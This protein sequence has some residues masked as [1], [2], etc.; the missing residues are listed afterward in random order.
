MRSITL[1]CL[2]VALIFAFSSQ[3]L[4]PLMVVPQKG[5][6]HETY[7]PP[8]PQPQTLGLGWIWRAPYPRSG[9]TYRSQG[10]SDGTYFYIVGGWDGTSGSGGPLNNLYRY[11]P[12]TNT[13]T[14]RAA[15][16]VAISNSYLVYSEADTALYVIG[17]YNPNAGGILNTLQRYKIATNSWSLRASLPI[18][19][20]LGSAVAVGDTIYYATGGNVPAPGRMWKYSITANAWDTTGAQC[21]TQQLACVMVRVGDSLFR[22]GGWTALTTVTIYRISTG[23]WSYG[24]S[25]L[26]GRQGLGAHYNAANGKIIVYG[27]A[28]TWTPYNTVQIYDISSNSWSYGPSLPT[29]CGGSNFTGGN[30]QNGPDGLW[31]RWIS[32]V[33]ATPADLHIA[34]RW[35]ARDVAPV[36]ILAPT[37]IIP[38]G[39]TVTPQAKIKNLGDSTESF[40]VTFKIGTYT[41]TKS[42]SNLAPGDSTIVDFDPWTSSPN[43]WVAS[44]STH[45][46]DEV[47]EDNKLEAEFMVPEFIKDFETDNGMFVSSPATGAWEWG[48][49]TSGPNSAHSGM[50]VW[51][52]NLSGNYPDNANWSLW[53]MSNIWFEVTDSAKI[54]MAFYH[55]YYIE[56]YWDGGNVKIKIGPGS[57]QII[58]P[59]GGYPWPYTYSGNGISGERAYSGVQTSWTPAIFKLNNLGL[60]NGDTFQI[61]F[62]FGSD[63]TVNYP[64][65]YIDDFCGY[66]F[67]YKVRDIGVKQIV[68]P[69]GDVPRLPITPTMVVKNYGTF[70]ALNFQTYFRI[71]DEAG[72][73][74]YNQARTVAFLQ[75]DRETT[76]TYPAWTPENVGNYRAVGI[77]YWTAD[78]NRGN[79]T[80]RQDFSVYWK[81]VGISQVIA[82]SGGYAPGT[83]LLPSCKV[84]NYGSLEEFDVPV[85][86]S[87]PELNYLQEK[88]IAYMPPD[89]EETVV[90][91][92]SITVTPGTHYAYFWTTTD[93]DLDPDNDL[94]MSTYAGGILDVG[95]TG[96]LSPPVGATVTKDTAHKQVIGKVKN[97]G[98]FPWSFWTFFKIYKG[99]NLVYIDSSYNTVNPHTEITLNFTPYPWAA[100][101]GEYKMIL[102][103]ALEGD[104]N[105]ANDSLVGTFRVILLPPGWHKMADVSGATKPVKSGGALTSLGDKV[106]ALVGNNTSDLMVYDV[107]S[108]T[109][110]KKSDVPISAT[111]KKKNV[112]KGASICTDGQYIYVIKGNNTQEFWRYNPATDS[113]KEYQVGF[114]KGIKGSSMTFDGDSFIYV[115]CGSNNNEWKRFNR[116]TETFEACNPATL[117]ADKW[118]TGSWIVY[119]PGDT[120]KIYALRVGGK[121]NEFYMTTIGGTW[122]N[123]PEMPL[124]GSTG[125]KKKVKEGSAGAYN[126]ST[127]KIYALKGGNTLEFFSF[128]PTN[129]SWKILE[130]V[131]QPEGTPAK[132]VKGGG[133]LTY[134]EVAGGLFA[135][136]GSGTNEFWF[137][138]PGG[139]TFLA[140]APTFN[141]GIQSEAKSLRNF[142]LTITKEKGY[143][144]VA[145]SLPV[146]LTAKLTLYNALGEVVYS[147]RSDKNYFIIDT[148]RLPTGIY[149][150]KFNANEYKATRKLVIH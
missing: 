111:G 33:Y 27:G 98:D 23:T 43:L 109:W 73:L 26:A 40:S 29:A 122:T 22:I 130:D 77:V 139:G 94:V 147:A 39:I 36:A 69:A 11:D 55:W 50:N 71:Y 63:Y 61:R 144:K 74:K 31:M 68:A 113:W 24:T 108:K 146:K 66:G 53:N 14:E 86:C 6:H 102:K 140:S 2:S 58:D 41:S 125:K 119:V 87:I 137:Y 12:L 60:K 34:G 30:S 52:T 32:G 10:C 13:W 114:S 28:V 128:N 129:D 120:P 67:R 124:V 78:Q 148:K 83:K 84:K 18:A 118:K 105:P 136:V 4:N 76:L 92:E 91:D 25:M 75:P 134:S 123:K 112:K 104:V 99:V 101:T 3:N 44:C 62:H 9:G 143:V 90:F 141:N 80:L 42:V 132:R 19:D 5:E 133:A 17:G 149:I 16:N 49:P 85:K 54:T 47:P 35:F 150:M 95:A 145:Y 70:T 89:W 1:I 142:T 7:S 15:C 46:D 131:G 51:A 100:D 20:Y 57:W 59:V 121:T 103:T 110:T 126:P 88:T 21:P 127:G 138:V 65:W 38:S 93:G 107:N 72:N 135:F 45:T 8:P 116:Y 48:Q 81:D 96:I 97:F 106:Y 37:G 82:P 79:D 117:P 56:A 64:G 115:I